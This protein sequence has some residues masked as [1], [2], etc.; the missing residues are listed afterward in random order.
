MV[1]ITVYHQNRPQN[2]IGPV[3]RDSIEMET[4]ALFSGPDGAHIYK[5]TT[6]DTYQSFHL[7]VSE[8]HAGQ[9]MDR[10]NIQLGFDGIGSPEN[11]AILIF[12]DFK[13]FLVKIVISADGSRYSTEIPILDG[14][15]D[16]AY[17]GRSYTGIPE[18]TAINYDEEQP[19]L[20]LIYDNDEMRV[21]DL[22]DLTGEESDAMAENDFVYYFSFEFEK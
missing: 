4:A 8:Y 5:F 21:I 11:G 14:V 2:F 20:A 3:E 1:A 7:F 13:N 19:L 17:Y 6:T 10:G 15:T 22:K 12:P 9:L 16:R 18:C